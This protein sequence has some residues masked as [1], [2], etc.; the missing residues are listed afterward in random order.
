MLRV[1][2][3]NRAEVLARELAA[4]MR[5]SPLPPLAPEVIL[6]GA[7]GTARWLAL[8]LADALGVAANVR[9]AFVASYVWELVARVVP[10]VPRE[11]PLEPEVLKWRIAALLPRFAAAHPPLARYLADG[12]ALKAYQLCERVAAAFDRYLAY[13]PEWIAKWA[14]GE[15]ATSSPDETWQAALWREI[16]ARLPEPARAHPRERFLARLEADEDARAALPPRLH[17]FAIE[18]LPP[19]YLE[20]LRCVGAHR[21]VHVWLVNPCREYWPLIEDPRRVARARVR[22][23]G[24]GAHRETGNR[25]LASLG[26]HGRALIDAL[27]EEEG[28][29]EGDFRDPAAG[30]TTLLAALQSDVLN[31]RER[32]DEGAPLLAPDPADRSLAIHVC[33]SPMREVEVLH[34]QLLDRF[35]RDPTLRP[36]D[37]LV[38]LPDVALYAPFVD[39]V[40]GTAPDARRIPYAIADRPAGSASAVMRAF[41]ALLALPDG[42]LEAEAVLALAE[43]P[44]VARRFGIAAEDLATLRGWVREAGIRWGRDETTRTRLGLPPERAHSWRAGLERLFLG[45]ATAGDGA[46]LFAGVAPVA[47]I[48]GGDALLAARLAR[49]AETTFEIDERLRT[50]RTLAAWRETLCDALEALFAPEEDEAADVLA[51]RD[52][53]AELAGRAAEA[54]YRERVPLAVVRAHLESALAPSPASQAFFAGGVTFAAITPARP[55]PARLVCLVG[56]ND[57]SFPREDRPPGFDLVAKGPRPGDRV[58]R[59]EDRYAFLAAL[60]ASRESLY[61]SYVGRSIRDNKPLPPS[62]LVAELADAALRAYPP[63]ARAAM[64]E[65]IIV[66]HPLQPFSRRYGGDGALFTYAAEYARRDAPPQPPR[67]A[68][69][70]IAP[71]AGPAAV[72]T[73]GELAR[74]MANPARHFFEQRLALRLAAADGPIDDAEPFA[75][76]ELAGWQADQRAFALLAAGRSRAEVRAVLRASGL[77]PEGAAGDAALEAR[78]RDIEPIVAA[79]AQARFRDPLDAEL[80]LGGVRLAVRLDNLTPEGR[81][82]WRAGRLRAQDRIAAWVAHL[83]LCALAPAGVACRTRLVTRTASTGFAAAESPRERL[84]DLASLYRDGEREPLPF[85]PETAHAYVAALAGGGREAIAKAAKAWERE[86]EDPY[87]A[88]GFGDLEAL[89]ER[90]AA[91]AER[92]LGPML[93]AE[94]GHG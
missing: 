15:S 70:R 86:R 37:V 66:E 20:T 72:V 87:F 80:D 59:D 27:V 62:P 76:D 73:I 24:V 41:R 21:D 90:F 3:S 82:A 60:L 77:L 44:I 18:A 71:P 2:P 34:D 63:E 78:L 13:R 85:F 42:R 16:A 35:E 83:A 52:A 89:D 47:A 4:L 46:D 48:E 17:L 23:A 69:R 61:V 25:L 64:R 32:G 40:F 65:S 43:S 81:L 19:P 67:F 12:D 49:F 31:L 94:E 55:V 14:R 5:G 11:S 8:A 51:I 36:A 45:Y 33:H 50:P 29:A 88:L 79:L 28:G 93:A 9:F 1:H 22:D 38:L 39:A 53:L 26:R 92:V 7:S 30:R 91:L 57:G 74:F 10:G 56:L 75:L 68:G 54:G 84:A 6:V 58:K